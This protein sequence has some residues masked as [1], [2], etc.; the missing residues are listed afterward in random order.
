M[1]SSTISNIRNI[2]IIAHIDAGKTTT[3]E[4]LLFYAKKEHRIGE[5]DEGTAVTD[6]M[7]EERIRGITITAAATSVDWRGS[8]INIIDTPGHVDFTAEVER[9]LRVLDGA[10]GVF[11]GVAGVQAQSETVWR[12]ASK[13]RVPRLAYIN[14][15]DRTGADFEK[16]LTSLRTK[17]GVR[18]LVLQVPV[19]LG[20]DFCGVIDLIRMK[21][22]RFAGPFGEQVIAEAVPSEQ[23]AHV[24]TARSALLDELSYHSDEL[25]ALHL[26]QHEVG[27]KLILDVVRQATIHGDLIPVLCGSSL[28]NVGIQP[29]LDA[30]VDFLP[31]PMDILC[32]DQVSRSKNGAL[33]RAGLAAL[34]FKV[35]CDA[36]GEIYYL[37]IYSGTLS[38]GQV[39]Y[40]ST[41]DKKERVMRIFHMHANHREIVESAS[42]G[43]IIAVVGLKHTVT[44]DTICLKDDPVVLER[45]VFPETVI[46]MAIEPKSAHE[47]ERLSSTIA[48]IAKEDPTF[49]YRVD[50]DTGQMLVS[51]M[52][53]LHLEIIKNRL[54]RDFGV[55]ANIGKPR[56]AYRQTLSE[57]ASAKGEFESTQGK[58][59][60]A[61]LEIEISPLALDTISNS[62]DVAFDVEDDRVPKVYWSAI[63][64]AILSA[65]QGGSSFGY[66]IVN[67]CVRVFDGAFRSGESNSDAFFA[68]ASIA[69]RE[70]ID[71]VE[72]VFL[73]PLMKFEVVVPREF[74]GNILN[75]LNSRRAAIQDISIVED[76]HI[77]RGTVPLSQ[78]FGYSTSV[79]SL[80]QGRAAFSMEPHS[81]VAVPKALAPQML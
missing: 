81:Y 4:R 6:W 48:L 20:R 61:K 69:F 30:V 9:S 52:G 11:C 29:L 45:I 47:R 49:K 74:Y 13:Y 43:D 65:A 72:L 1:A 42:A 24:H 78:F 57:T 70:A 71:K 19:G 37:R 32:R 5:V 64:E 76:E 38:T 62:V 35:F 67:V 31:S 51:G 34:C 18:P 40:N 33:G 10:V 44:G 17:L 53:E 80:S 28:K 21:F 14:K 27:E 15:L 59:L 68:A 25:L 36:H 22:L 79:R 7:E 58:P 2:G 39:V 75:D 77:L 16:C 66:P 23:L 12:Q 63:R 56:V 73:E 54:T 60:Y 55:S 46:S 3:T 50:S 8:R 41:R 26:E